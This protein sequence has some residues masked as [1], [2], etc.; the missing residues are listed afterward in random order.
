MRHIEVNHKEETGRKANYMQT[1]YE[2]F[3]RHVANKLEI[4]KK[5]GNDVAHAGRRPVKTKRT[6][7]DAVGMRGTENTQ[8]TKGNCFIHMPGSAN[9][10]RGTSSFSFSMPP[11]VDFDSAQHIAGGTLLSSLD[12]F[13][14][15]AG[16]H[17]LTRQEGQQFGDDYDAPILQRISGIPCIGDMGWVEEFVGRQE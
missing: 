9:I 15:P 10:N 13:P 8:H 16:H 5:R 11:T 1:T 3:R 2:Y 12:R 7:L 17:D 6:R 4:A 14:P